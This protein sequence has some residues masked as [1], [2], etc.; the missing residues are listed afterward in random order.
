MSYLLWQDISFYLS[1]I[2]QHK[3]PHDAD[4]ARK[5]IFRLFEQLK[6]IL[7]QKLGQDHAS[8][9]L[10]ALVASIDE[11][12]QKMLSSH[13]I[14]TAWN[15]LAKDFAFGDTAGE[16][17]FK[18]IDN[19][20]DNTSIPTI[21]FEVFYFML[22]RG[23]QGNYRESKTQLLKYADL[24]RQKIPV[25]PHDVKNAPAEAPFSPSKGK[26]SKG[27]YYFFAALLCIAVYLSLAIFANLN[28]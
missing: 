25:R 26:L 8:S 9:I 11:E 18:K 10:F 4:N 7:E 3:T 1:E 14:K 15:P 20:L 17:F 23:F 27:Y 21:V 28:H 19:M 5:D 24:L 13:H 22:R 2:D 16:V 6:G 12:M